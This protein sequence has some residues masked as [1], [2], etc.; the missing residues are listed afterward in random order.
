MLQ[1]SI[2]QKYVIPRI[3]EQR[4]RTFLENY[5]NIETK[6]MDQAI[7][8]DLQS[9]SYS[10]RQNASETSVYRDKC[11][12]LENGSSFR[13]LLHKTCMIIGL[14]WIEMEFKYQ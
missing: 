3:G 1:C 9:Y 8:L 4:T 6:R 10:L 14:D 5:I 13:Q 11:F 7:D 12:C 2:N